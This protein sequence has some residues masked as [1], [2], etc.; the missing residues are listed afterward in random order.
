MPLDQEAKHEACQTAT[1]PE[2]FTKI[3]TTTATLTSVH[4][5]HHKWLEFNLGSGCVTEVGGSFVAM[6]VDVVWSALLCALVFMGGNATTV[7]NLS[8]K[9]IGITFPAIVLS[10]DDGLL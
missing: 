9:S 5:Q 3:T 2:P 8:L 10:V 7:R 4:D 6:V 1:S